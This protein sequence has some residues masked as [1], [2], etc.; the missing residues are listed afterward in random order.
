VADHGAPKEMLT[1]NGRQYVA[2]QGKTRF[3]AALARDRVHHIRSAPHHPMTLGKIERFWKTI[4]E[5]FLERA[6][7]ETFESA[8]ERIAYWVQYYNH[9]RPHQGI[10]GVC[11]A[12]R[13]FAIQKEM[14]QVVEQGIAANVEQLALRGKPQAPFYVVGRVGGQNVVLQAEHGQVRILVDGQDAQGEDAMN[15]TPEKTRKERTLRS[16]REK[17]QAVLALWTGRRRPSEICRDLQIPSN[18]LTG[19][20]ERAMEGMLQALEPRTRRQ[21][22]RGPLLA[23]RMERLLDRKLARLESRLARLAG[24]KPRPA[25]T[26]K[27]AA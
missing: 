27:P 2:W 7:F 17:C 24:P 10:D 16:A 3:Q 8:V 11:P 18:L 13:Y 12:E 14:R 25:A 9:R 5:E 22:D 21:E 1:D 23:P 4:W 15:S 19:W 26:E 6:R 20:Q